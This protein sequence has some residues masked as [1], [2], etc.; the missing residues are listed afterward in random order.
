MRVEVIVTEAG[1]ARRTELVLAEG[2]TVAAALAAADAGL[3]EGGA[4]GSHG[5]LRRP[6]DVLAD[7]DRIEVYEPLL[8]DPKQARRVRA[9]RSRLS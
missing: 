8:A 9:R 5:R 3:P 1:S 7:G 6:D 4:V 2:A